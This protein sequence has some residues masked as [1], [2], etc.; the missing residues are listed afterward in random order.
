MSQALRFRLS[1]F[2]YSRRL[3]P[4]LDG[5]LNASRQ[6]RVAEHLTH[7][8][9][10]TA[11]YQDLEF[12]KRALGHV[13]L[14]EQQPS[15]M[16]DWLR[17]EKT[18]LPEPQSFSPWRA[19]WI[20]ITAVVMLLLAFGS[21]VW[22]KRR[23]KPVLPPVQVEIVRLSGTPSLNAQS[24]QHVQTLKAGDRLE[25]DDWASALLKFG[26]FGQI[27]A[28]S[29]TRLELVATSDNE[30]RLS[31]QRGKIYA[32]ITAP[33]RMF[34][35][36][37]P[38]ATAIDMGCAYS[39]EVNEQGESLLEVLTGWVALDLNGREEL[40]SAGTSC[41]SRPGKGPGTPFVK[42]ASPEFQ[43]ALNKFD[44][45][46][47][48][49][50]LEVVRNQARQKD[51][52]TLW[53]LLRKIDRERRGEIF[54]RLSQLLPPPSSVTRG[55]ILEL[56]EQMLQAWREPLEYAALGI[57]PRQIKFDQGSLTPG[58]NLN[59]ARF[60]HTATMLLDGRVL[61][62]GGQDEEILN[63]AEVYDPTTGRFTMTGAMLV[64]RVAHSATLL[65]NGKVLIVGGS[66]DNPFAGGQESAELFD[67][68]SGTFTATGSMHF[69]RMSHCATLL[70]DGRVLISGGLNVKGTGNPPAEIYDPATGIF[71]EVG[72]LN[73]A[74]FDH[75]ATLLGNGE[76]LIAGGAQVIGKRIEVTSNAE[77]FDPATQTFQP[78][79]SLHTP[80]HKHSAITLAS[81]RV[82]LMGGTDIN[83][84]NGTM[85]SAE[86]YDPA[87]RSFSTTGQMS[88]A[89]YK[90]RDA[91]VGLPNGKILVAGGGERIEVYD[92]GSGVFVPVS[93]T[94][95]A[96]RYM[97]TATVLGDGR[98][99]IAGGYTAP[100]IKNGIRL[101]TDGGVWI[102]SPP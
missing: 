15:S 79:G 10:C 8:R 11:A 84:W 29:N 85:A 99:L 26:R 92:P 89:R 67:P 18:P 34:L 32:S 77:T 12:A 71:S 7:C 20:P 5:E 1:C 60:G 64:K 39:L 28:R 9:R 93:G 87:S 44:F 76:V 49:A 13:S 96:A 88:T 94:V 30:Q 97:G 47:D 57:D 4:Y 78:A 75:T 63:S 102:Y 33:P 52:I 21:A 74:R 43:D 54:D 82:L 50:A 90:M 72:R 68:S 31:L 36:H 101:L 65:R 41:R 55:G 38:A 53:Y 91:V 35:V 27:E 23:H 83:L 40:V 6:A 66:E 62:A 46:G 70:Q 98:V 51:A 42:D 22:L 16:P 59:I 45:A 58:N 69:P 19:S 48:T 86:L 80:R 25:T 61:F 73:Y 24:L 95:G 81:G 2:A 3:S 37:T 100:R 14:P 56:N 17:D